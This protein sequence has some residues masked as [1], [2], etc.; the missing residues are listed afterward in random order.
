MMPLHAIK[1]TRNVFTNMKE[2]NGC[3]KKVGKQVERG[4]MKE[5]QVII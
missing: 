1:T 5:K 3:S 2:N 4:V